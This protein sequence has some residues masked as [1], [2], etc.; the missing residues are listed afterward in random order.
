MDG[1]FSHHSSLFCHFSGVYSSLFC[2][3]SGVYSSLFCQKVVFL[4]A[5]VLYFFSELNKI[6]LAFLFFGVLCILFLLFLSY[7]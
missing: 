7:Q 1:A 4:H 6:N 3:F 5:D 2:H